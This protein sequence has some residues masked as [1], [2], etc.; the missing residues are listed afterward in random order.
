[1]SLNMCVGRDLHVDRRNIM[2]E[3]GMSEG[4]KVLE[5]RTQCETG[6]KSCD[7]KN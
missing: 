4:S 3:S 5:I 7:Y 2:D 1:M 6:R